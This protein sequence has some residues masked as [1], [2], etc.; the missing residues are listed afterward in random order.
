MD[1]VSKMPMWPTA[2]KDDGTDASSCTASSEEDDV[3]SDEDIHYMVSGGFQC[4][5]CKHELLE[6]N[7]IPSLVRKTCPGCSC[8]LEPYVERYLKAKEMS[9]EARLLVEGGHFGRVHDAIVSTGAYIQSLQTF[10]ICPNL[11]LLSTIVHL[12]HFFLLETIV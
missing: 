11:E 9:E 7:N 5:N 3:D 6:A 8:S 1:A 12:A 4:P 10:V 2:D